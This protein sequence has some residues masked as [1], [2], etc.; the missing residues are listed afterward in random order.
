MIMR[1]SDALSLC[2]E[3]VRFGL[4]V[5][6]HQLWIHTGMESTSLLGVFYLIK[7]SEI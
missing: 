2:E 4:T 3:Q 7:V 1:Y 6:S 5:L